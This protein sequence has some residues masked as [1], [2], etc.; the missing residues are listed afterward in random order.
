MKIPSKKKSQSNPLFQPIKI[1]NVTIKNRFVRSATHE[2]LCD[3][4]GTPKPQLGGIYEAVGVLLLMLPQVGCHG[5]QI[6]GKL[7]GIL[8]P[9]TPDFIN[10]GVVLHG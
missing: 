10:D 5:A 3:E 1:G 6:V 9:D 2:W 8:L 7:L 4:D